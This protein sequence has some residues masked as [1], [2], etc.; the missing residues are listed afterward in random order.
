MI[1]LSSKVLLRVNW[2][3]NSTNP[4]WSQGAQSYSGTPGD[5]N[6]HESHQEIIFQKCQA[7][8]RFMRCIGKG[9]CQRIIIS[10][11][12]HS[13]FN[14]KT[15]SL[16]T[17]WGQIENLEITSRFSI[18]MAFAFFSRSVFNWN[19]YWDLR[20]TGLPGLAGL[21]RCWIDK[22]YFWIGALH[23]VVQYPI[24]MSNIIIMIK[25]TCHDFDWIKSWEGPRFNM[26]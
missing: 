3:E 14:S 25:I 9:S 8:L 23:A 24:L 20:F 5:M 2:K 15:R 10:L 19:I 21:G 13:P 7:S 17:C 22:V 6:T 18:G 12:G 1:S 16:I 26:I 4:K 11:Q